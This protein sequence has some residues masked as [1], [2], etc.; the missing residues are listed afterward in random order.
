METMIE[1]II[2]S[3]LDEGL[4]PIVI[5]E[6]TLREITGG[7]KDHGR[8]LREMLEKRNDG[9]AEFRV[10]EVG[11]RGNLSFVI[12]VVNVAR[13]KRLEEHKKAM[14]ENKISLSAQLKTLEY[15]LKGLYALKES[16]AS[17]VAHELRY[18]LMLEEIKDLEDEKAKIVRKL[19]QIK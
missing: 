18:Y 3:K 13:E 15:M 7:D 4:L 2:D 11:E 17:A 1:R 6:S 10:H 8:I 14:Q 5:R 16:E 19:E 9:D 12:N